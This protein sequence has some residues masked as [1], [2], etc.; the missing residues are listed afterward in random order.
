MDQRELRTSDAERLS[1]AEKLQTAMSEGFLSLEEFDERTGRMLSSRTRGELADLTTDLPPRLRFDPDYDIAA[2]RPSASSSE[3][4]VLEHSLDTIKHGEGWSPP[5]HMIVKAWGGTAI[6]DF[7][8]ADLGLRQYRVTLDLK[9][10]S[11]RFYLPD[12]CGLQVAGSISGNSGLKDK[13][14]VMAH[15]PGQPMFLVDG[16]MTWSTLKLMGPRRGWWDT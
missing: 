7:A 10:S 15:D 9:G 16:T 5:P 2:A 12:G 13:R 1:A 4:V 6:L 8:A 14:R 11:A 3:P